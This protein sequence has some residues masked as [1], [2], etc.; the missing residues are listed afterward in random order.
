V[1][2]RGFQLQIRFEES[3]FAGFRR[4]R[5]IGRHPTFISTQAVSQGMRRGADPFVL[6]PRGRTL[7]QRP[8][9]ECRRAEFLV[10]VAAVR[11]RGLGCSHYRPDR[12]IL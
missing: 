3:F 9:E 10:V 5:E 7:L 4:P 1:T 6:G 11:V 8:R 12:A 2:P